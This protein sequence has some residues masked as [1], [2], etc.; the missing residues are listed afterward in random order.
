[1][2]NSGTPS[3]ERRQLKEVSMVARMS[4]CDE[5]CGALG[6]QIS[7]FDGNFGSKTPTFR[8]QRLGFSGKG[9]D[10]RD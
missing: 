8:S 2:S 3:H 4:T 5:A 9:L 10:V 1:M 7:R 6:S